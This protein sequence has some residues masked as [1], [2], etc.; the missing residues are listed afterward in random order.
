MPTAYSYHR[1]S[2]PSQISKEKVWRQL[3]AARGYADR[4][5]LALDEGLSFQDLGVSAYHGA[6]REIGRLGDFLMA[7]RHGFVKKGS[8]LLVESLDRLSRDTARKALRTLEDIC[9]EGI[10]VV[11]LI[12]NQI[13]TAELLDEDPSS[14]LISLV[15]F[16]RANEESKTKSRR[17]KAAWKNKIERARN[18]ENV[19]ITKAVPSWIKIEDEKF[20]INPEKAKTIRMMFDLAKLGLG[21]MIIAKVLNKNNVP[22]LRSA[23]FWRRDTVNAIL[24]SPSVYGVHVP[25]SYERNDG[26]TIMTPLEGIEGY[27][28][29]IVSKRTW[30]RVQD[31]MAERSKR[32]ARPDKA[33]TL[34]ASRNLFGW[35]SRCPVC[36]ESMG[37]RPTKPADRL[38]TESGFFIVC[39]Y[40]ETA[41]SCDYVSVPYDPIEKLFLEQGL[42][43]MEDHC[44]SVISGNSTGSGQVNS[45]ELN[46]LGARVSGIKKL[47][48]AEKLD[49]KQLNRQLRNLFESVVINHLAHQLEF[50]WRYGGRTTLLF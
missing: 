45:S 4:N 26:K 21:G 29:K 30:Q 15:I 28:P 5:G 1:F 33:F 13:Y 11:T 41:G 19:I 8:Y 38:K 42:A 6:N 24:R 14:L 44:S 17:A 49:R 7:V 36:G 50:N 9:D 32:Y 35:I 40:A 31:H 20:V 39:T 16:L 23:K 10:T 37:T 18:G 34:A 22:T 25:H 46:L 12:D 48:E 43:M 27:F 47:L 2:K 3:E